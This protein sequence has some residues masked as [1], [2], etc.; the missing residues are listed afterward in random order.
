MRPQ[1]KA[2]DAPNHRYPGFTDRGR[3]YWSDTPVTNAITNWVRGM[4]DRIPM[5]Q[6]SPAQVIRELV[7][8]PKWIQDC[9]SP[10]TIA[11]W[12]KWERFSDWPFADAPSSLTQ[13]LKNFGRGSGLWFRDPD[14]WTRGCDLSESVQGLESRFE[15]IKDPDSGGLV[16]GLAEKF[17]L[18]D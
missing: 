7:H 4:I 3:F 1:A 10:Y 8:E 17:S 5:N 6:M 13:C 12:V 18:D 11:N 15:G 16:S 9:F 14:K 2:S